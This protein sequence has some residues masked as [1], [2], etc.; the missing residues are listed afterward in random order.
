MDKERERKRDNKT[1]IERQTVRYRQTEIE[2][3]LGEGKK[4]V[5]NELCKVFGQKTLCFDIPR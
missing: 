5:Y 1:H 2:T 3:E 4:K